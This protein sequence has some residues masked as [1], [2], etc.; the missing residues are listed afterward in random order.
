MASFL[1]TVTQTV[2]R[3][4]YLRTQV[5][6]RWQTGKDVKTQ[7]SNTRGRPERWV[8]HCFSFLSG[9]EPKAGSWQS[10]SSSAEVAKIKR[11]PIFLARRPGKC[12]LG[13]VCVEGP[14]TF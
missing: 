10:C 5:K 2:D 4:D 3:F 13:G 7:R 12:K 11:N 1:L 6:K 9:L 8:S 14:L